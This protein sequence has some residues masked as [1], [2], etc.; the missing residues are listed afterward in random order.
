MTRKGKDEGKGRRC[1]EI[2]VKSDTREKCIPF[3]CSK[4]DKL[5]LLNVLKR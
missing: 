2:H 4:N 3:A 5:Q 1:Q